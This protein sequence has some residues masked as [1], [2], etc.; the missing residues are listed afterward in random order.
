MSSDGDH[1]A[2]QLF[3]VAMVPSCERMQSCTPTGALARMREMPLPTAVS[4][5]AE[6]SKMNARSLRDP[7]PLMS[8]LTVGGYRWPAVRRAVIVTSSQVPAGIVTVPRSEWRRSK[9]EVPQLT[10]LGSPAGGAPPNPPPPPLN[11]F[12]WS[13][14]RRKGYAPLNVSPWSVTPPS[15]TVTCVESE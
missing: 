2:E 8:P 15:E 12:C 4:A 6:G 7:S 13:R 3:R 5:V 10:T 11:P 14:E 1:G 9:S